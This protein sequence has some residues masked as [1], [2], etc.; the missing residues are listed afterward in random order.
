MKYFAMNITKK[1]QAIETSGNRRNEVLERLSDSQKHEIINRIN[2][3]TSEMRLH[4]L[5]QHLKVKM[6]ES[7]KSRSAESFYE[8]DVLMDLVFMGIKT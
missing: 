8:V 4:Q 2:E 5:T 6:D 7:L 3:E 1:D